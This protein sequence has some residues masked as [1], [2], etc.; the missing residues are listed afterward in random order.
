[1]NRPGPVEKIIIEKLNLILAPSVLQIENESHMHGLPPESE[2]HFRLVAVS[3]TFDGRSRTERH[4]LIH[5]V[6]AAELKTLI[7]ALS[8]HTFTPEEWRARGEKS[9][10]ASPDCLGGGNKER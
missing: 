3:E 4:Q 1:M 5:T 8:I 6:L 2:K 10:I 9:P 7:H